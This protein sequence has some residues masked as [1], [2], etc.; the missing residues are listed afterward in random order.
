[1]IAQKYINKVV[2]ITGSTRCIG[3]ATAIELVKNGAS[4]VLN[5]RDQIRLTNPENEIKAFSEKVLAV[6][7]DVSIP[8]QAKKLADKTLDTFGRLDIPINDA[9]VSMRDNISDLKPEVIKALF[10]TIVLGDVRPTFPIIPHR[11]NSQ[12]SLVSGL[13]TETAAVEEE[14]DALIKANE[15]LN[16]NYELIK[17]IKGIGPVVATDLLIKTGN[18]KNID[19]VRKAASYAG[20]YSFPNISGKMVG[21]SKTSPCADK[22]LKSLLYMGAKSAAKHNNEYRLYYQKKQLEG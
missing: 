14:L 2:I 18:F 11:R 3:K 1:M 20:V 5:G 13:D 8:N 4:V 9:A 17:G 7:C 22:K 16:E 15:D 12:D 10:E 19:T 6:C 21:K